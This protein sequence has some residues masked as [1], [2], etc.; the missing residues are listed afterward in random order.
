MA[1]KQPCRKGSW[2]AGQHKTQYNSQL[3]SGT[4]EGKPHPGVNQT[5][6]N[7][8][9]MRGDQVQSQPK[10]CVQNVWEWRFRLGIRKHFFTERAVKN[11][12]W[13]PRA[14]Q[15]LRSIWTMSLKIHFNVVSP[16][17]IKQLD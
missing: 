13:L 1:G 6:A 4:Q 14:G 3:C 5:Q 17:Y 2:G 8:P 7:Q 11:W 16:K 9:V 10:Y 15:C 12:N